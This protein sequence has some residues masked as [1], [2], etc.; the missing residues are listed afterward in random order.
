MHCPNQKAWGQSPWSLA[1]SAQI[2]A[3]CGR[4]RSR[5]GGHHK[6]G[7]F[8]KSHMHKFHADRLFLLLVFWGRQPPPSLHG[9]N[10]DPILKSKSG[11]KKVCLLLPAMP[12]RLSDVLGSWR[13]GCQAVRCS[14]LLKK[15]LP[16]CQMLWA[17]EEKGKLWRKMWAKVECLCTRSLRVIGPISQFSKSRSTTT[18][19]I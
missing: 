2:M 12:A 1:S 11:G 15:R 19:Q 14:G 18:V 5:R 10:D 8:P 13:R 9:E 6:P 16:G 3:D 7:A 17:L 4:D